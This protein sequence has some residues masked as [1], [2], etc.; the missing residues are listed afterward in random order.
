MGK[1]L[2]S[3]HLNEFKGAL[4]TP[5][6]IER[7]L[8]L[9]PKVDLRSKTRD[10]LRGASGDPLHGVRL[11]GRIAVAVCRQ[12]ALSCRGECD[13]GV[14]QC[15]LDDA[16]PTSSKGCFR[17][18]YTCTV[19]ELVARTRERLTEEASSPNSGAHGVLRELWTHW[20]LALHAL[21]ES[22]GRN[23]ELRGAEQLAR[24]L[25]DELAARLF[26]ESKV[27][28]LAPS[29][30]LTGALSDFH[31]LDVQVERAAARLPHVLFARSDEWNGHRTEIKPSL[32]EYKN[33]LL[34]PLNRKSTS[35]AGEFI[36]DFD[37]P[38]VLYFLFAPE[39]YSFRIAELLH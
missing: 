15:M 7:A 4:S 37:M 11:L 27:E 8:Q 6:L 24:E 25:A 13:S 9:L 5:F 32:W 35:A 34:L 26:E 1:S 39:P 3:G 19:E 30:V 36:H 16:Q 14:C 17:Q 31:A 20:L 38:Q 2:Q 22:Q 23:D 10:T 21:E 12:L 33:S 18:S 29:S 28:F